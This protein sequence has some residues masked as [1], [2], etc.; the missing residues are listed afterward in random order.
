MLTFRGVHFSGLQEICSSK[1]VIIYI[2]VFHEE[3]SVRNLLL[4]CYVLFWAA[5]EGFYIRKTMRKVAKKIKT[6]TKI[7]KSGVD[8]ILWHITVQIRSL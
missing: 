4:P 5:R 7:F 3:T 2:T 1:N 6:H 8:Q